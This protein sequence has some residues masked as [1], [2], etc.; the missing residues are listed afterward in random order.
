MKSIGGSK[1]HLYSPDRLGVGDRDFL[2][3]KKTCP[4]D[5]EGSFRRQKVE[6]KIKQYSQDPNFLRFQS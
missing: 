2:S 5:P 3:R 1:R 4:V 6:E